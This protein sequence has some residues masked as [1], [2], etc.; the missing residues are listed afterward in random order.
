MIID[1]NVNLSRW[2]A[3]R[4]PCDEPRQLVERLRR[5]GV[6]QAWAGS[7][8]GLLHRDI[9]GVN[10]RLA[11]TCRD[12]GEG[13][14]VPF[15]S[16]NPTLPDWLDD[17][18]RCRR[19]HSMPGIRLHP[20]YHGYPL[21]APVFADVLDAAIEHNL[22]VQLAVRMDDHRV[23]QPLLHVPDVDVAPLA[24]L[25]AA[26]PKLRFV[27][28]NALRTLRGDALVRLADAGEVY[29]EISMLEGVGAIARLVKTL[30]VERVLFGSHLPLFYF[31]SAAL[32]MKESELT[33]A[34]RAAILRENARRL[35]GAR[36]TSSHGQ[37]QGQG[38]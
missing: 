18:R 10:Q 15:G 8:D 19:E 6:T 14:L 30:P 16:V 2:P 1:V 13:L 12:C 27:L 33:E 3:R 28:L 38:P 4:L 5:H 35:L 32:K 26:R 21:D 20:N 31:E 22:I 23:Q 11:S 25:V 36:V 7:F 34:Q 29:F 24:E 37:G 9:A 17:V